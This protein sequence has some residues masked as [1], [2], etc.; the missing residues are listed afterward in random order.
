MTLFIIYFKMFILNHT[1]HAFS[2]GQIFPF[3]SGDMPVEEVFGLYYLWNFTAWKHV[4]VFGSLPSIK[5]LAKEPS[6]GLELFSFVFDTKLKRLYSIIFNCTCHFKHPKRYIIAIKT[7]AV[8]VNTLT[9]TYC[10]VSILFFIFFLFYSW[11]LIKQSLH[12]T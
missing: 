6:F 3:T 4:S 5:G 10:S 2:T 1:L 9:N 7:I 12:I 11:R 8:H